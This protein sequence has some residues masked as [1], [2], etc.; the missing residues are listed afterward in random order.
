MSAKD[1]RDTRISAAKVS[2]VKSGALIVSFGIFASLLDEV[3]W[4]SGD[5]LS[6]GLCLRLGGG[7]GD[8]RLFAGF[9][10]DVGVCAFEQP[11]EHW[12]GIGQYHIECFVEELELC[13]FLD[14]G[15]VGVSLQLF[16][17][18]APGDGFSGQGEA[19]WDAASD[20]FGDALYERDCDFGFRAGLFCSSAGNGLWV[21]RFAGRPGG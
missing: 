12:T 19:N 15:E 11:A 10:E 18:G 20:T 7:G 4:H 1:L 2:G 8:R 17:V 9:G 6:L 21:F 13:R 14:G 5:G 3:L 16:L